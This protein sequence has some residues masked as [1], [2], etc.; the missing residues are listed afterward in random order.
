MIKYSIRRQA[1]IKFKELVKINPYII[2]ETAYNHEGDYN[3]LK[4]M[5]NEIGNLNLNAVKFH[6]LL[7]PESYL[8]KNH[9][10][11]NKIKKWT[12][13]KKEWEKIFEIAD[14]L[15]LDIVALCDDFESLKFINNEIENISIEAVELHASSLNDYYLLEEAAKFENQ[16]ILGVGGSTLDEIE[17]AVRMLKENNKDDIL[18]MYGFQSYP[19]DYNQINLSKILKIKELFNLPVGYADHTG[20]DDPN[21]IDISVMGSAMG[22]NVLEKHYTTDYGKERIDYQAAV[23]K[24][25]FKKIKE[26]M[27]IYLSVYGDGSL[28]LSEPELKYGNTGP[29]K[30]AIVAN[31]EIKKGEVLTKDKL[32]FKRTEEESTVKQIQYQD[33]LGL[34]ANKEIKE[35]EIIDF[36]K[37]DYEFQK[38][39]YEDLT[40]GLEE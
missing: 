22:I 35:D 11:K 2:A 5:V 24:E 12:F 18:L 27:K 21:N 9:P 38:Q 23:G 13:N 26:K 25:H 19:T 31:K 28:N 40:G 37:V 14:D 30:K 33:L 17:F 39:S 36:S 15:N 32:W 10:L 4:K 29:M 20:Y 16:V 1:I 3:Y 6:L 8:Q 7:D 34:K